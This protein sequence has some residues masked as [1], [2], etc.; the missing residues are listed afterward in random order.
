MPKI[1]YS[2]EEREQI[3]EALIAVGLELFVKQGV[4]HTTV[5][6][7]YTRVG[8]SRTFFYTFFP[9]KEDLVVQA[10]YRQRPHIVAH[11]RELMEDPA[12]SW[13]DGVRQFLYDFCHTEGNRFA[14]LTVEEQQEL[15]RHLSPDKHRALQETQFTFFASI[16][17]IFGIPAEAH[18]AKF[19]CNLLLSVV[20][21]RK[22]IPNT[23][24]FLFPE[25][26]DEMAAFQLNA[27]LDHMEALRRGQDGAPLSEKPPCAPAR[28]S[29]SFNP[30]KT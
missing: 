10:F 5:Q 13:R 12:L 20:I 25:A 29:A 14:I 3:R 9:A 27:L 2:G 22:A 26:A 30:T 16:L 19:L 24:P 4:Q 17:E 11:A 21:V 7:I 15:F 8:I 28:V 23:L 18:T 6:Q 1:A